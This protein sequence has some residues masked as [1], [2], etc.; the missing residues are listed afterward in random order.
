MQSWRGQICRSAFHSKK[1]VLSRQ[2]DHNKCPDGC[3][4]SLWRR[5]SHTRQAQPPTHNLLCCMCLLV[6][7]CAALLLSCH[8]CSFWRASSCCFVL[9]GP[10]SAHTP[11]AGRMCIVISACCSSL[12]SCPNAQMDCSLEH[13]CTLHCTG[14]LV[15]LHLLMGRQGFEQSGGLGQDKVGHG[16]V[17][18]V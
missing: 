8:A 14:S 17:P 13:A 15:S 6:P 18:P 1:D 9:E 10:T 2:V 5:C 16:R 7:T 3:D 11:K 4:S 12:C